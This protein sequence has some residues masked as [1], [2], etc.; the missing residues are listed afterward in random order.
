MNL[1]GNLDETLKVK[2]QNNEQL[3]AE[4]QQLRKEITALREQVAEMNRRLFGRSKETVK[5]NEDQL[6]L[7]DDQLFSVAETTEEETVQVIESHE[8]KRRP[9]GK[10]A[11][12]I[13][14]LK[15]NNIHYELID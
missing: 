7:F 8:R 6:A 1:L 13:K 2:A 3:I 10:K 15:A 14:D 5:E 11:S 4:N 9:K 12:L